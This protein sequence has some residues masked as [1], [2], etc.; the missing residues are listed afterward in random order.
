MRKLL[1]GLAVL[2]VLVIAAPFVIPLVVPVEAYQGRLTALVKQATGRDLEVAGPVKLSVFPALELEANDVSFANAPDAS[3]P[4]MAKLKQLRVR[5]QLLPLLHGAVVVS[6]LVLVEPVIAFEVDKAGH[7]NWVFGPAAA[8]SAAPAA[9]KAEPAAAGG[10]LGISG[11]AVRETRLSD[12]KISYIDQRTG[13]AERLDGIN[14]TLSQRSLDSA[15]DGDGS[16]VWN[17]ESVTLAISIDKPRALLDGAESQVGIKFAAAP[18]TLNFS[19]RVT[20]LPSVKLDGVIDLETKSVRQLAK[21]AGSPISSSGDGLGPLA[22][23]GT[24]AMAGTKTSLSDADLALGATKAK[25]SVSIDS[26]G[27]RPV[28]TGKLDVDKLDLNPYLSLKTASTTPPSEA[29]GSAPAPLAAV[30]SDRSDMSIA[31]SPLTLA[32]VDFD[33]E[34][35]GIV[36]RRFQI[37]ASTVG[38]RV[39]DGRLTVELSR[40]ALYRGNGRGTVTVDGSSA[41][42]IIGLNVTLTQ[43]QIAPLAQA[44]IDGSRLTGAGDL[45]IAVTGRGT[46]ERDFISTLN[47]RGSLSLANGQIE[48]VDLPALAQSAAKIERDFIRTLNVADTLKLLAHGQISKIPPLALVENAARSFVGGGNTSNFAALTAT[49]AVTNGVLRNNDL[50]LRFGAVPMTGAGTVD[51]RTRVVDYRVSVQLGEGVAVPIQVNGTWDNLNYQPDM[52]AMLA[53]TPGNALSVLKSG[54]SSVG[55]G[56]K[57]VGQ[58]AIGV[59][60]G[61]FGK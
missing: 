51:L 36:Y 6:R 17:G 42:P 60:K 5:L 11:L 29:G 3:T 35:G 38:V 8:P 37:S 18:I 19:G 9:D 10:G 56:L 30:Q 52:T 28:V 57:D 13:K 14:M 27:A 58:D 20:G 7:P 23:R 44:A 47:G 32:D 50:Q 15:L 59:L 48:G 43:V 31:V 12:G 33:L 54:G 45:D 1:T 2:I 55:Q 25:G 61:I 46:S 40:M 49:C 53:Q 34:V 16:A 4:Q 24:V 39:K 41:V 26:A 21:W 22:I